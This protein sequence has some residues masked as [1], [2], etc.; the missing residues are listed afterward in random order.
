MQAPLPPL[1]PLNLGD[2]LDAVFRLYRDNF[3][4][5]IGI[6]ALLQVPL[7]IFQLLLGL[8][9]NEAVTSDI[10]RLVRELPTFDPTRDSLSDL[11][12]GGLASYFGVSL[13]LAMIQGAIILQLVNGAL[14]SAV[15][16]R[17]FG[18]ETSILEAYNFGVNRAVNLILAGILLAVV[19]T[20]AF[21]LV[22]GGA[23]ALVFVLAAIVPTQGG[24][25]AAVLL[26]MLLV[27]VLL[28]ALLLMSLLLV[29]FVFTVQAVVLE[30]MGPI[31]ALG[32]SWTLMR[33]SFWRVLGIIVLIYILIQIIT[34][35]PSALLGGVIGAV[36]SEL[37]QFMLQQSL[38]QLVGYS[39]Q[40]FVLPL[41][42]IGY[43]L[44][45]YD[46]RVRKEGFDIE[47]RAATDRPA[48]ESF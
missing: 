14:A 22:F 39:I 19:S 11:P 34:L 16:R 42:L 31:A 23:F 28:L 5:F 13:F 26:T 47:L 12:I 36:F 1:R 4:T 48:E 32:R 35:L 46:V 45:Y 44:L 21:G 38:S 41:Q 27:G 33:G 15:S 10:L 40:I 6:A 37:D 7:I 17:Y 29:R 24:A 9:L 2:L 43:T 8:L 18:R 20:L 3:L 30:D 25:L